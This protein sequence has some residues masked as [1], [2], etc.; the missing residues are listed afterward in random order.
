[1]C[2]MGHMHA[3]A[4]LMSSLL[5]HHPNLL[6]MPDNVL[7]TVYEFWDKNGH[8]PVDQ[9]VES[10]LDDY[11]ILFDA[12]APAKVG[13]QVGESKGWTT[14]GEERNEVLQVDQAAFKRIMTDIIGTE[15]KISR[16]LFFQAL[17]LAYAEALGRQVQD[18]QILFGLHTS[19]THRLQKFL[20]DFPEGKF[21]QMVRHPMQA[22]GTNF[23]AAHRTGYVYP[24]AAA[25][26]VESALAG[27]FLPLERRPQW[28]GVRMEDV[29]Q[30]SKETMQRVCDW[31]QIP[32]DET[33]LRSTINGK[34]WWN[35]KGSPQVSGP[36]DVIIS[37]RYEDYL[38]FFDRFR[39]NVLSARICRVHGYE[40]KARY[41]WFATRLL[42]LPLLAIPLISMFSVRWGPFDGG[43]STVKPRNWS[44]IA[45]I[46]DALNA[47]YR[48][49]RALFV[50]W[51]R[52][53][54]KEKN[55]IEM[56]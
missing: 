43:L 45:R 47:I 17:H 2:V 25:S 27:P 46:P 31:L 33:V 40:V 32:W 51:L 35:E 56:I 23:K 28:R 6:N 26:L 53:F 37:Q 16:K 39:L 8:L 24:A 48:G 34:Q 19:V 13:P 22:L 9:L 49:R 38:P 10:F 12:W 11:A 54:T 21:L 20:D 5:D 14:L 7:R 50:A 41:R 4:G 42:V 52:L 55:Q 1:V 36:N 15:A 44:I 3:G 18:P 29:H 30:F